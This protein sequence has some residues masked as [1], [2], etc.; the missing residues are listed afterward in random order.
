M[1]PQES[2]LFAALRPVVAALEQLEVAYYVA[3]SVAS[4]VLGEPRQTLGADIVAALL[5]RHVPLLGARL[6]GEYFVDEPMMQC[7]IEHQS[8]FNLIHLR[9]M[10]KVDVYI[11]WRSEFARSQFARRIRANLSAETPLEIYLAS[12]E[13]TVLAKLDWYRQGGSVSDRQWRD[14][15][16]VLK[17]QADAMD[18]VYLCE[19]AARL[20][21][22][23]LLRRAL[24]D[25]ELPPE[26]E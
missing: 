19:W 15:L 9:T 5:S 11:S 2:E 17:V 7:A 8:S 24:A 6:A 23:D 25:A 13:D 1:N 26:R 20:N 16:G 18:R 10:V 12:A 21:L 14:V 22:T 4:G 3:G